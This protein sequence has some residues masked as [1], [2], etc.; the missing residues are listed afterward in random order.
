MN[1][2]VW[3][4]RRL[5]LGLGVIAAAA[6]PQLGVPAPVAQ[7]VRSVLS[8]VALIVGDASDTASPADDA[9]AAAP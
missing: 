1:K 6:L 9:S 4:L 5:W 3:K 7:A 8:G 2:P